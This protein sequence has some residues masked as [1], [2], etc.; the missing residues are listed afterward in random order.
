[1]SQSDSECAHQRALVD[2]LRTRLEQ[3]QQQLEQLSQMAR[4]VALHAGGAGT[5][6]VPIGA[7]RAQ[8]NGSFVENE[9]DLIRREPSHLSMSAGLLMSASGA[10]AQVLSP[11]SPPPL[12]AFASGAFRAAVSHEASA[13]GASGPS[14]MRPIPLDQLLQTGPAIAQTQYQSEA[15]QQHSFVP[16]PA[17]S[18][19]SA[20]AGV[21]Q[22]MRRRSYSPSESLISMPFTSH[23]S[24]SAFQYDVSEQPAYYTPEEME[25][26]RGQLR[27]SQSK[28]QHL[29]DVCSSILN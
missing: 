19:V 12:P 16:L 4:P 2:E 10:G 25:K 18:S 28:V 1:M 11:T 20:G 17:P 15:Q 6:F 27:S 22:E 5:G 24:S 26:V 7:D 13:T 8:D 9:P 29:T 14:G 23:N 21:G 3:T